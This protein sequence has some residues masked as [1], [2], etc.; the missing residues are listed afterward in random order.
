MLSIVTLAQVDESHVRLT[1]LP[2]VYVETFTGADIT[3]KTSYILARMWMVDERDSVSFYDSLQIR[4]RGNSTWNLEKKPY[5]LKFHQKEK[6]LGKGYAKTKKWTLLANHGDKTLMRNALTRELGEWMGMDFNPAARFVDFTLNGKYL[7]NYQ[8]SDHVDVRPHRVDIT[9][10]DEVLGET[11][12]I[13]G[14]YLLEADGFADFLNGKTGFYTTYC[15]SPIRIHYPDEDVIALVQYEYISSHVNEFESRLFGYD[16]CD[17]ELGYRPYVDSLSLVNWYLVNEISGNLDGFYSTY[18]Y[19]EQDDPRLYWGPVWDCDIAYANDSR[20]GDTSRQLMVDVG[21]GSDVI[22]KWMVRLWD[23]PWFTQLIAR[24]YSAAVD[25]GL[26]DFMLQKIDS[27]STLLQASQ[28]LNFQ[29]WGIDRKALRERVLYSSYDQYVSDLRSFVDIHIP[30]LTEV[31]SGYLPVEPEPKVPDFPA[32]TLLY[33]AINN[34]GSQTYFDVDISTGNVCA[35]H[36]DEES[37]TQQWRI[38]TLQNGY[39]FVVNRATGQALTDPTEGEVSATTNTGAQLCIAQADSSDLRQQWDFV[40]QG[41]NRYNLIN[42]HTQHGAN[43]SGG[44]TGNGTRII[45]YT[46]DE[47]NSLSRNRIWE[48]APVDEITDEIDHTPAVDYALAYDP[49]AQR[50]HFGAADT[51]LLDFDVRV[52]DAGGRLVRRFRASESCYLSGLPGGIYI[53]SWKEGTQMR[54]VKF[55]K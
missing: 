25:S 19:K 49:S 32:G 10:Q 11:S 34:I 5:K 1:N 17:P 54:S 7:G 22:R 55:R 21:F 24:R 9:E 40:T 36:R 27:L 46:N 13:T 52:Y 20:K 45:S 4:G 43:L 39:L 18:F 47:R 29:V 16:F 48:I 51:S 50:L 37:E 44:G 2:H 28:E 8:I 38:Y 23:D 3:S 35:N 15:Q 33:Y 12:N 14:G 41:S 30:Y 31:L 53:V 42:H 26:Q 6:L